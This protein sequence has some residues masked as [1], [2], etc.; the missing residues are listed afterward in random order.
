MFCG[1]SQNYKH[2]LENYTCFLEQIVQGTQKL[3]LKLKN[4]V[5]N[6]LPVHKGNGILKSVITEH[7]PGFNLVIKRNDTKIIDEE[8][9]KKP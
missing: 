1:L 9:E 5:L 3:A 8:T 4:L 7:V 6:H 2:F